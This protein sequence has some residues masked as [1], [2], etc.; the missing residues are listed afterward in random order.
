MTTLASTAFG[1]RG[2][3][4]VV[5]VLFLPV[6][7]VL[8]HFTGLAEGFQDF[9]IRI[10]TTIS[11]DLLLG[12]EL[13]FGVGRTLMDKLEP[14]PRISRISRTSTNTFPEEPPKRLAVPSGGVEP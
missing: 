14:E 5:S 7:V 8:Q 10:I 13:P 11:G 6:G 12:L 3:M 9:R 2:G 4:V 1:K